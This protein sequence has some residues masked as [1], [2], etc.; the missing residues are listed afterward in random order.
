MDQGSAFPK[1]ISVITMID[2]A[3]AGVNLIVQKNA[4]FDV[5]VITTQPARPRTI[6]CVFGA[7][8]GG[9]IE[10]TGIDVGGEPAIDV[11]DG[12]LGTVEGVIPFAVVT[13]I[14][15]LGS[16]LIAGTVDVRT[17]LGLGLPCKRGCMEALIRTSVDNAYEA[18]GT[19]DLTNSTVQPTTV[20]NGGHDYEFWV[21]QKINIGD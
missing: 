12:A 9:P 4:N 6:R 16:V 10:I 20:P 19:V 2:P 3:A 13:R 15:N 1:S 5:N 17:G 7:W 14:R 11:I 18:N 8:D 21:A